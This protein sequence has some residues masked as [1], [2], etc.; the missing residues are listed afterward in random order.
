[1]VFAG[2]ADFIVSKAKDYIAKNLTLSADG[3]AIA[4]NYIGFEKDSEAVYCYFEGVNIASVKKLAIV[5]SL[6][7]DYTDKQINILHVIVNGKRQSTKLD[8]TQRTV[9]FNF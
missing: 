7:Q 8:A 3:K 1:M 5:N 2:L 9:S 4:L 6:L